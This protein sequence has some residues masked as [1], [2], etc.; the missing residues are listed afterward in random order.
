MMYMTAG[1]LV[2][3]LTGK[4]WEDAVRAR[5]F[6][7]L[8]MT[9]SNVSVKELQRSADHALPYE[10]RNDKIVET[11]FGDVSI[12][13]P[14]GSINSSAVDMARCVSVHTHKGIHAGR[15]IISPAVLTDMHTPHMIM[16]APQERKEIAPMGYGLGWFV[17]D[18]RGHRRVWHAGE[19]R[20]FSARTAFFPQDGLEIVALTN[21]QSTQLPEIITRYAAD[22]ILGLSPIDWSGEELTMKAQTKAA[23]KEARG[24]QNSVRKLGTSPAHKLEEYAGE[25][26]HPRLWSAPRRASGREALVTLWRHRGPPGTLA[27]RGVQRPQ[28]WRGIG[29]R[30]REASVL[31]QPQ[32]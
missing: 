9:S 27:L 8:G 13:G 6:E 16:N 7:P 32:G 21:L 19:V 14:A 29:L 23:A 30:E 4:P 2:E 11:P 22:R 25:Y 18:Y 24:K 20:G 28:V 12:L 17:D 10:D 1:Y 3:R 26:E 15:Q 5:V 31:D